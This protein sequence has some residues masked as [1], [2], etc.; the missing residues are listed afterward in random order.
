MFIKGFRHLRERERGRE[1]EGEGEEEGEGEGERE[2]V[3]NMDF[4][5]SVVS[6]LLYNLYISNGN[7]Q[8]ITLPYICTLGKLCNVMSQLLASC[9]HF[10]LWVVTRTGEG[11][12]TFAM[13]KRCFSILGV[14][15]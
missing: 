8:Y 13:T 9:A 14:S 2:R 6:A 5:S 11:L 12:C 4:H 3:L 15:S 1:G 7:V 10:E